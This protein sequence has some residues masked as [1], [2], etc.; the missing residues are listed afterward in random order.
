MDGS[1]YCR[2]SC[3]ETMEAFGD[4]AALLFKARL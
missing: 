3:G 4:M 1:D 2:S